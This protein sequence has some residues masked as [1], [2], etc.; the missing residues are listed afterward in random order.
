MEFIKSSV[1]VKPDP[2]YYKRKADRWTDQRNA[3]IEAAGLNDD[4]QPA[5]SPEL[6]E[7]EHK[8]EAISAKIRWAISRIPV[9]SRLF[10]QERLKQTCPE[11]G[12][13]PGRHCF[14]DAAGHPLMCFRRGRM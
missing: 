4:V 6:R 11:C 2:L 1:R 5:D 8:I 3:M 13:V 14:R 7:A 12:E 9:A 10:D